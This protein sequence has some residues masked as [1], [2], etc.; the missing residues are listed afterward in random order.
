MGQPKQTPTFDTLARERA[1]R[2]PAEKGSD[3]PIFNE[4]VKPIIE[5]FNAL[6]DDAASPGGDD[7]AKGLMSLAIKDIGERVVFDGKGQVEPGSGETGWGNRMS[8]ELVNPFRKPV[9]INQLFQ[10]GSRV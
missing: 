10:Y 9:L 6:F 3:T 1:F 2:F 5:S 4:F 8:S 7:D